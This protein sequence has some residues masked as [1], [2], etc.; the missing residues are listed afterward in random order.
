[1]PLEAPVEA[2]TPP[3]PS[4]IALCPPPGL[5]AGEW[6]AEAGRRHEAH[7]L[8][9]AIR[10]AVDGA[11]APGGDRQALAYG[12]FA[13]LF[14][15][16]TDVDIYEAALDAF[17]V[18][19]RVIG[20][21]HFYRREQ[22]VETLALLQAVDDPLN[23][24]AVVAALRSSYF[25]LSDEE[26]FRYREQGGAWNYLLPGTQPGP[27]GEAMAMLASWHARRNRVPPQV[28]LRQVFEATGAP[29]A[30]LLKP[31]GPQRVANLEKLLN[32]LRGLAAATGNF[33][34]LVR[35]L[36]AIQEAEMPEEESSVV[37]PGDD[38]VRIMSMH[39][40]KG[41]QFDAVVLPDLGRR[42]QEA[43]G[44]GALLFNRLD[45][46]VGL[47]IAQGLQ[48]E[49][50]EQLAAE[51][52]GNQSAELRRLLYV[53]CTRARRLLILP[54]HWM[55]KGRGDCFQKM[56]ADSGRFA[57]ADDVP[58]GREREGVLYLD[59]TGWAAEMDV[60][61]R[62]YGRP[63][64]PEEDVEALLQQREQWSESHRLLV[65]RASAAEPFVLPSA[66]EIGF[67][68][69]HLAEEAARGPGGKDFGSLF[70]N[71]MAVVPLE[72]APGEQV[73]TLVVNM[74]GIE[75]DA[76]GMD[77]AAAKEAAELALAALE[78]PE[79]RSLLGGARA[80]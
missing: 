1:V 15:A 60:A 30:F 43:R 65:R 5:P 77:G 69:S 3:G 68:P 64:Q 34:A 79:F 67:E 58:F 66:M 32:Q 4:V 57:A 14:R 75:A 9:R 6:N 56:L 8:A 36:S 76:L 7:Y 2:E 46:R 55:R 71:L 10:Q 74:A 48:S 26:L 73:R 18:P 53:A 70:H 16:L 12:H 28:L 80:V 54:L 11:P 78:N 17:D 40:A 49:G 72:D 27:V 42:F 33:G 25:G 51:E 41:L 52:R 35:H 61:L 20:G 37:E 44:V 22:I 50:Y 13:L 19:Y 59:T 24:A 39:K 31:A 62:P 63:E 47:R 21:K 45:G 23:E 29:Q 38:F